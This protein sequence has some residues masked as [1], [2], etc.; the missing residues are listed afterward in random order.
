MHRADR[1][2]RIAVTWLAALAWACGGGGAS[3][4]RASRGEVVPDPSD[5]VP[6]LRQTHPERHEDL[7]RWT[8]G[9]RPVLALGTGED[10]AFGLVAGAIFLEGGGIAAADA[11]ARDVRFFAPDGS[12]RGVAGG[13]GSGPGE[14]ESIDALWPMRRDSIGAFDVLNMRVTVLGSDAGVGRS[15]TLQLTGVR[16][17]PTPLAMSAD[18]TLI[19]SSDGRTF[20]EDVEAYRTDLSVL[21]YSA[22]GSIARTIAE[23]PGQEMWNLVSDRGV[24]RSQVP[25]GRPTAVVVAGDGIWV[26]TNEGYRLDRYGLDGTVSLRVVVDRPARALPAA[27]VDRY[28][29]EERAKATS[30]ISA[31]GPG[32]IFTLLAESAPYPDSLP[33]YDTILADAGGRLWVRDYGVDPDEPTTWVVFSPDGEAIATAELPARFRATAIREGRVLGV[34]RDELDVEQVRVYELR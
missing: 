27:A 11:H 20:R 18:G 32:E 1:L 14:F 22:D 17:R 2:A 9:D 23:I 24:V 21:A 5:G 7:P 16:A 33:Q 29:A 15:A 12:P 30:G 25:F 10:A 28:R 31:K 13:R 34:W 19:A 8:T 6:L 4:D 26:G 3:G